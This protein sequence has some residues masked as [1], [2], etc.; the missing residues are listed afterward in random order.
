MTALAFAEMIRAKCSSTYMHVVVGKARCMPVQ[1]MANILSG[2]TFV[3]TTQ[4]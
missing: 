4:V 3:L 2:A 1:Q